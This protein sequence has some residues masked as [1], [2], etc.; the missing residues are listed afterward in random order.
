MLNRYSRRVRFSDIDERIIKNNLGV[1]RTLC[2][3]ILD[4]QKYEN[5]LVG[6]LMAVRN[7]TLKSARE[8]G[9]EKVLPKIEKIS[10]L[11]SRLEKSVPSNQA[12][13]M[14]IDFLASK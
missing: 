13:V 4:H 2:Q 1:M 14:E 9:M 6:Q 8:P 12:D 3:K 5:G 11:I 7:A 10:R